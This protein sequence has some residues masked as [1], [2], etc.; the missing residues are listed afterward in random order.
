M[1][2]EERLR[3]AAKE[4]AKLRPRI[5]IGPLYLD[6]LLLQAADEIRQL[7]SNLGALAIHHVATTEARDKL[8]CL[9]GDLG[10]ATFYLLD[11]CEGSETIKDGIEYTITR[12][13]LDAT[14]A[15]LDRID[16]LPY[17]EPDLILGPG[18]RLE[19]AIRA[20]FLIRP[21][22]TGDDLPPCPFCGAPVSE[23]T[24]PCVM[25]PWGFVACSTIHPDGERC[26]DRAHTLT[27]WKERAYSVPPPLDPGDALHAQDWKLAKSARRGWI[28]ALDTLYRLRACFGPAELPAL[29]REIRKLRCKIRHA[30]NAIGDKGSFRFTGPQRGWN[31]DWTPQ[32]SIFRRWLNQV[33]ESS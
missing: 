29:R 4:F 3:D 19:A 27:G 33:E 31:P 1:T 21:G 10:R 14:S 25:H 13:D 2:P 32:V 24:P 16:A 5:H 23:I 15:V 26:G 7:H 18:A 11:N 30:E 22:A 20:S 12:E 6:E 9:I 8:I 28:D 17:D